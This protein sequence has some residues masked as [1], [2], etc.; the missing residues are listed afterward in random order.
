MKKRNSVKLPPDAVPA[1][2]DRVYV[3]QKSGIESLEDLEK[4]RVRYV[5]LG[6]ALETLPRKLRHPGLVPLGPGLYAHGALVRTNEM[7][8]LL[9]DNYFAEVSAYDA[10]QIVDRRLKHIDDKIANV[11]IGRH[12]VD[13]ALAQPQRPTIEPKKAFE[14]GF[15]DKPK[16]VGALKSA[17]SKSPKKPSAPKSVCFAPGTKG[18]AGSADGTSISS[19]A[20]EA[21]KKSLSVKH[22][23]NDLMENFDDSVERAKQFQI[24]SNTVNFEELYDDSGSLKEVVGIPDANMVSEMVISEKDQIADLFDISKPALTEKKMTHKDY[25][26]MLLEAEEEEEVEHHR[27]ARI[28]AEQMQRKEMREF[29]KGLSTG[30]FGT[31]TSRHEKP[32]VVDSAAIQHKDAM[33]NCKPLETIVF[34]RETNRRTRKKATAARR[35][36]RRVFN[37]GVAGESESR[38]PADVEDEVPH[39]RLSKF[40][41]GLQ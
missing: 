2:E 33:D 11:N 14:K 37:A 15:L 32:Q 16:R 26:K 31:S 34:E 7:L 5:Q 10:K 41:L 9:G 25:L 39:V 18:G 36:V 30:F 13:K 6:S 24:Q 35:T 17:A 21:G 19:G 28:E 38:D 1:S 3:Y 12:E 22:V 23:V 8:A 4:K 29:G 40:K 27:A 20:A